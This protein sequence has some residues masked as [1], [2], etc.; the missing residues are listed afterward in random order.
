MEK[1]KRGPRKLTC[2]YTNIIQRYFLTRG[3]SMYSPEDNLNQIF[4]N[5][6]RIQIGNCYSL[7]VLV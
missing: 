2:F 4:T 7:I 1:K 6:E 3:V 5:T